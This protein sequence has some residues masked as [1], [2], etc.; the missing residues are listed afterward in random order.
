MIH[1]IFEFAKEE[2]ARFYPFAKTFDSCKIDLLQVLSCKMDGSPDV[3][4]S[5]VLAA[6]IREDNTITPAG[7]KLIVTIIPHA[8]YSTLALAT[9]LLS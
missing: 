7:G 3:L 6:N 8:R 2:V 4:E 9:C 5:I 1:L